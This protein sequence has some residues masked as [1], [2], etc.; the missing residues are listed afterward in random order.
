M[1]KVSA[2][3]QRAT[4]R[5]LK[6]DDVRLEGRLLLD[7]CGTK[8]RLAKQAGSAAEPTVCVVENH[9]EFA[10]IEITCSC[11]TKIH[12]RCDYAPAQNP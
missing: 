2:D 12:L 9:A 4:G 7:V 1:I 3:M 6:S 11:G 5:V 10:V 8:P